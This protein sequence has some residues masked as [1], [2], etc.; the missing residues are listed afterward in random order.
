[1]DTIRIAVV[2]SGGMAKRRAQ[3]FTQTE[4]F[5]LT[6]VAA[7][8]PDTGPPLATQYGANLI[9]DWQTLQDRKDVDAV[10]IC[11]HNES[12]GQIA[13]SSIEAGKHVFTEYPVARSVEEAKRLESLAEASPVVLRVAHRE[14]ISSSHRALKQQVASMGDLLSSLFVRLTPGR[15]ARPEILFNLNVS[16]PPALFFVYHVYPVLDLFGP[17][18]WVESGAEYVGLTDNGRYERFVN[19]LTVGFESGG[20]GQWTWA[21]GIAIHQAEEHQRIVLTGG[22]LLKDG[23]RWRFSDAVGVK[24]LQLGGD[25]ERTLEAQFLEDIKAGEDGWRGDAKR[26]ID[27]ARVG[28]AAE[29]SAAENRRV[30]VSEM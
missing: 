19:T 6:A 23:G 14:S 15:G 18:G 20:L 26:A 10:V 4:G 28:L 30:I 21:G 13:I 11:T 9:T 29:I 16:G 17:V 27:A 5:E 25:D 2:G 7:R 3:L 24:E 8:N 1:M 22:T 12:H